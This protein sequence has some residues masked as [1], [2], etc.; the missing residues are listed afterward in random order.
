MYTHTHT[1]GHS[2]GKSAEG[3][4]PYTGPDGCPRCG[5][6]VYAAEKI[7]GAGSVSVCLCAVNILL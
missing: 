2:Y 6:R 4:A 5:R 3:G 1:P 7:V